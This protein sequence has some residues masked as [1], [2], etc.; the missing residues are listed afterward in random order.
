M[1]INEKGQN[2]VAIFLNFFFFFTLYVFL[3]KKS[4]FLKFLFYII[5]IYFSKMSIIE[6]SFTQLDATQKP[7]KNR[8]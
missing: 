4:F 6:E 3:N 1:I 5:Y 8:C 7:E 2:I